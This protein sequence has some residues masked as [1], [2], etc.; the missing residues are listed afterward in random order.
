MTQGDSTFLLEFGLYAQFI[1]G[2]YREGVFRFT[3]ERLGD[4]RRN[5]SVRAYQHKFY[6]VFRQIR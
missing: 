3:V 6:K 5:L 1:G 2:G 4:G